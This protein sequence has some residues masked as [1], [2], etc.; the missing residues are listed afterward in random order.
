M[1]EK[2]KNILRTAWTEP[3]H[4]FFWLAVLSLGGFICVAAASGFSA[5][6]RPLAFFA[7]LCVL[8]LLMAGAA[9]ILA[10][11]PPVRRLL[12]WLL[13]RRFLTLGCFITL[14]AL[15]YAVENYRGRKAW[16]T[17][18][19]EAEA[20]GERFDFAQLTPPPVPP[21]QNFFESP[22][23]NDLQF[24]QTKAGVTWRDTNWGSHVIFNAFG[25]SGGNAPSTSPWPKSQHVD[26]TAWQNFYRG[27]NNLFPAKDGPAT[28][29][30]PIA[31][32]PQSPAADVLLALSKF[33][34]NRKLLLSTAS[35]PRARFW[36]NWDAGPAMLLPHLARMKGTAQY[37]SLHATA[38]L[39]AGDKQT[40]IQDLQMLSRLLDVIRDEP[41]LISHLVRIAVSQIALQTV[42]EG[43]ADRQWSDADLNLLQRELTHLDFLAD[44]KTAMVGEKACSIWVVD[45][46]HK[47]G[48]TGWNELL[49]TDHEGSNRGDIEKF[50]AG[51]TFELIP[52]GWF[53]QNKLSLCRFHD[54]YILPSVNEQQH[55]IEPAMVK[56]SEV[57]IPKH[58]SSPY[59]L[60]SRLYLPAYGRAAE[61]FA[62]A[63]SSIDLALTACALERYRLAKG[64]FPD[65][66]DGL[67]PQFID[68]LPVDVITGAPLKYHRN[69]D[70]NFVLYSV[71][72]NEIDDGGKIVAT[73]TG[74]PDPNRGDWVWQYT[75][76]TAG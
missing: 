29:Y 74:N 22:L 23:W 21:D 1:N 19:R 48:L 49:N 54:Q 69:P 72:W 47:A 43:L 27:T 51:A 75:K 18:R 8:C 9:F 65:T 2:F 7:L 30:F 6:P 55:R 40:A 38:A 20:Q 34:D 63:Q 33:E 59:D 25:P 3:R 10:W 56:V 41:V 62:R 66:L 71:G 58:S 70:G 4:F 17:F 24:T 12:A 16:Q 61:R 52:S 37:L 28:N 42:W 35:R 53:D 36:I 14:V 39:Q 73:K 67:A 46:V 45:Y 26:L 13:A 32:A 44:Y 64:Q 50:L 57:A 68:K 5:P 60:L 11:I 15:F 31:A 76:E